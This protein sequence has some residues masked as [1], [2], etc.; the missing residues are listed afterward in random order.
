M[1]TIPVPLAAVTPFY[2]N[3]VPHENEQDAVTTVHCISELQKL[4]TSIINQAV[5][6]YV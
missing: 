2:K 4:Q 3:S 5:Y 6:T 1:A